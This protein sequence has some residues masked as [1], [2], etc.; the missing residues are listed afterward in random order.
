MI[1]LKTYTIIYNIHIQINEVLSTFLYYIM[2]HLHLTII[3]KNCKLRFHKTSMNYYE[4]LV[5]Q[6]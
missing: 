1:N 2:V 5:D 4:N 3:Q 6:F